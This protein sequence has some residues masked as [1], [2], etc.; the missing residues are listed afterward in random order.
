MTPFLST[1]FKR[2]AEAYFNGS[3]LIINSGGQGSSKT[4]SILQLLY[5]I[6][7]YR[8]PKRITIVSYALPHLKMGVMTDLDKIITMFGDNP[9]DMHNRSDNTYYIGTSSI[10]F[11][12]IEGNVAKAHGPRR[13]ILF[14]N[15]ANRKI[16]YEIYD[17]LNTRTQECTFIDFNPDQEFWLH[18][19]V[20]PNFPHV[21]VQSSYLDNPLL[22]DNELKNILMKKDK[23]GFENWWRVYGLGLLGKLEGA[24]FPNWRFGE[25]DNSLSFIFGLDFGFNDPDGMIK[26]AMDNK[27]KL[28]YLKECIYS[29]GN[30]SEALRLKIRHWIKGNELIIGDC[31][32][33]RM[34]YDL[35]KKSFIISENKYDPGFNIVPVSKGRWTISDSIKLMQSYEFIVDPDSPNL[36]KEFN[37]Y[38]W[39]DKKAG[40]PIDDFNHLIDPTR[41]C[42]MYIMDKS[43]KGLTQQN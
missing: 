37:N 19:M 35:R 11:F 31:A 38:L 23:P 24:I 29:S 3:K 42:Y 5:L 13:D 36:S 6:A 7:K 33:P 1:I 17:Q 18:E 2:N 22:P 32:D 40:I 41:Y 34:I 20:V 26:Y 25:F 28:I 12:G 16:T 14:I 15:E 9:Y 21:I 8:A 43:R 30:S 10:E 4:Y 27:R 39:N